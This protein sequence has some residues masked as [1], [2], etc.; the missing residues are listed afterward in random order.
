MKHLLITIALAFAANVLYA[1]DDWANFR[2]YEQND[3][4]FIAAPNDGRRVVFLGNSITE[5]WRNMRPE[6]FVDN[7]FIARGIS[8]Q[9]SYQMLLRFRADVIAL[10]PKVVIINAGTNDIAQNNHPYVEDRTFGNI[11][12]MCEIAR[13]NKV[14]V[15]LSTITPCGG[16]G[17]NRSITDVPQ[18]IESLN[19]RLRE[20]ARQHKLGFIDYYSP[21]VVTDGAKKGSM[22]DELT[23]DGCHPTVAG[24]EIM[25][26]LALAAIRRFVK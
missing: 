14:K 3:R 21:M 4:E 8:G 11:V 18:K 13:A 26:P 17:W 7:G 12:S 5:N 10:K 19:A 1:Q 22:K 16:Y 20:Y 9:T 24:Y 2:K 6:F 23:Q 15:I 25:E